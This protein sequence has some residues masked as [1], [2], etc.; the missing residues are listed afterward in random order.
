MTE[1]CKAIAMD[2]LRDI[3]FLTV[4]QVV[5]TFPTSTQQVKKPLLSLLT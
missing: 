2:S 5:Q 3:D 4:K 1:V